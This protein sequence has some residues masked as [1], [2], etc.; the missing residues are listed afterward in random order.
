MED[1]LKRLDNLTQEET[2]MT[3][4]KSLRATHAVTE[5]VISLDD[6]VADIVR[7]A[8]RLPLD[9]PDMYQILKCSDGRE[10]K[11]VMK[12][13][14]RSL[15]PNFID[16]GHAAIWPYASYQKTNCAIPST[17]GSPHRIRRLTITSRV[18]PITRKLQP[19][20]LKE[21]FTR[22]GNQ[23]VASCGFTESVR[24]VPLLYP[25]SPNDVFILSR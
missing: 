25:I 10:T 11:Q 6:K 24:S 5:R 17:N 15:S 9:D 23:R 14:E 13:V 16:I 19:G 2:R 21:T 4:A 3:V 1:A 7:G 18:A 8:C 12:Q 22:N 20:S